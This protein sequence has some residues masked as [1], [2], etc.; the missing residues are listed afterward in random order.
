MGRFNPIG[1]NKKETERKLRILAKVEFRVS[2][3][4]ARVKRISA[5]RVCGTD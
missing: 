2:V 3:C 5:A 4:I 1:S